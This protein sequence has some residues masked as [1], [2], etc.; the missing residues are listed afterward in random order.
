[1]K[2]QVTGTEQALRGAHLPAA[3]AAL[4]LQEELVAAIH[5]AFEVAVEIAVREVKSLLGT[6]GS[7]A[8]LRRENESLKERLQRAE[9][10]LDCRR[11]E[12]GRFTPEERL[13][14]PTKHAHHPV[15]PPWESG[16]SGG[17]GGGSPAGHPGYKQSPDPRDE[18][19]SSDDQDCESEAHQHI[20]CLSQEIAEE[21][22][23]SSVMKA[24]NMKASCKKIL[25]QDRPLPPHPSKSTLEQVTVKQEM[26]DDLREGSPSCLDSIKMED[27]G[28]DCMSEVQS[29]MLEEQ[30][31]LVADGE[32]QDL[33]FQLSSAG[34]DRADSPNPTTSIPPV[35]D[36]LALSSE[37]PSLFQVA[38]PGPPSEAPPPQVYGVRVRTS[39]SLSST[40]YACK[41]CG[42]AFQLPSLL[43][44]HNSQCQQRQQQRCQQPA[45]G[46]TRTRLQ[47]FPPG[48]SPFRCTVC[49]REFNRLENLKTH[50]RIHTG[51]RPY[52]C[53]VCGKCFRHSGALKRHIRIHTGEKPYVCGQCGKSFRNWGGLKFHQRSHAKQLQS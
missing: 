4:S 13:S 3:E 33:H 10:E 2:Q 38:D 42:Q 47:L 44:R 23:C 39:R 49:N 29:R 52:T 53:S 9:A 6:R 1:M 15:S 28:L 35:T 8:D 36:L 43:R 32:S 18:P 41:T 12:A 17:R 7:Y 25:S 21:S 20:R 31:L 19:L 14:I 27:Y 51:E 46:G 34:P 5:G 37:F 45:A 26:L 24:E 40:L 16:C 11:R 30:K 48:C 22:T 50:L